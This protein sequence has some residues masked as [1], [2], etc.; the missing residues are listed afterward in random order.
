MTTGRRQNRDSGKREPLSFTRPAG[1]WAPNESTHPHPV[2]KS[3]TRP[4]SPA[5]EPVSSVNFKIQ[6]QSFSCCCC[7]ETGGSIFDSSSFQPTRWLMDASRRRNNG[8]PCGQSQRRN[9]TQS[10]VA[11][12]TAHD[13]GYTPYRNFGRLIWCGWPFY[14]SRHVHNLHS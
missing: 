5:S 14:N 7:V 1:L 10:N 13:G 4:N 6:S 9:G 12:P 2:D 8:L 3:N 11:V